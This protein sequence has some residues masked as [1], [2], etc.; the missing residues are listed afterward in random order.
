[1]VGLAAA[2]ASSGC[3]ATDLLA[4]IDPDGVEIVLAVS[5]G[6]VGQSFEFRVDGAAL[7]VRGVRC[8]AFCDWE[9]GA[10]ILPLSAAQVADL[11]RRLE[12]ADVFEREGDYG[13]QCCDMIDYD[14]TYRREGRTARVTGTD[15]RIPADLAEA[16][17]EVAAI[18]YRRLPMLVA[19]GTTEADWPRD[20]Y[21]L[22]A[23]ETAGATLSAEVTYGGGCRAH[24]MDLVAWG[25]W[26]ESFPVQVNALI[27]HDDGDDP[28]D[29]VITET[30]VFDLGPLAR[31]YREAYGPASGPIRVVLRFWDPVS[32]SPTGRMIEVAL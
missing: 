12:E 20:A 14:L 25:G 7:E 1:M 30:R 18:G 31:A 9:A 24:R 3:G 23:V 13:T 15:A 19:P 26:M 6:F 2:L 28:C 5:G 10:L 29:A 8:D 32:G 4:P 21:T 17:G 22:G 27:T 16:I 11:A